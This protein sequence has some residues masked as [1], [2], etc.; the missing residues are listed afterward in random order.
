MWGHFLKNSHVLPVFLRIVKQTV[1]IHIIHQFYS[2]HWASPEILYIRF[3][4]PLR[5]GK[6]ETAGT[7][8]TLLPQIHIQ[9]NLCRSMRQL[10]RRTPGIKNAR[11]HIIRQFQASR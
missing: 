2:D 9:H 3:A 10:Q 5:Y 1:E 6:A 4:A 11:E 7:A 8:A